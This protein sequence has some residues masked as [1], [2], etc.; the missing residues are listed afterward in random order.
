MEKNYTATTAENP[1][2]N[3]CEFLL[4]RFCKGLA[5]EQALSDWEEM[6]EEAE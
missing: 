2:A 4:N 6:K 3:K 5:L 1:K